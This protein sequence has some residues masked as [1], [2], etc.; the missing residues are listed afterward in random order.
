[1]DDNSFSLPVNNGVPSKDESVA[2]LRVV[3]SHTVWVHKKL[4]LEEARIECLMKV[5]CK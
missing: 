1:M 4:T 3:Q 5:N 2:A